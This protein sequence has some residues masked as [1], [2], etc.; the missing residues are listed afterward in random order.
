[1]PDDLELAFQMVDAADA[2]TTAAWTPGGMTA[3]RKP[4]GSPVTEADVAAEHAMLESLQRVAP[5]HGFLGEEIGMH[6]GTR[7]VRRWIADGI[8]G[9]R[10]FAAGDL[11][12]GTLLA[13][14]VDGQITTAV[15]SSPL[16]QRRW[17]AVRGNGAFTGG[18]HPSSGRPIRV[19]ASASLTPDTV[20]SKPRFEALEPERQRSLIRAVGAVGDFAWSHQCRVAE[21]ELVACVWFAGDIWDHAAPSLIVEEAGGRFSDH[22]GGTRLDTRTA[23]YSNG[24]CH[25]ALLDALDRTRL[26]ANQTAEPG[27]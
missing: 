17:W 7:V 9:T 13:L 24:R 8:D 22:S 27:T 3:S 6:P 21:G 2:V 1:M 5:E 20:T 16:Q 12:W 26:D 19:N 15:C 11:T 10:Y 18:T 25:D 4:D 14:E 23:V